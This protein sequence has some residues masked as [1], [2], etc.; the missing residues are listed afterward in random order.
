[1][2]YG[3]DSVNVDIVSV[4]GP[5]LEAAPSAY[6]VSGLVSELTRPGLATATTAAPSPAVLCSAMQSVGVGADRSAGSDRPAGADWFSIDIWDTCVE[7]PV[8]VQ[9]T[10]MA[11]PAWGMQHADSCWDCCYSGVSC[12]LCASDCERLVT[13]VAGASETSQQHAYHAAIFISQHQQS[14]P[15]YTAAHPCHGFRT[16]VCCKR[17]HGAVL[18]TLDLECVSAQPC[19]ARTTVLVTPRPMAREGC[20]M[21]SKPDDLS[22]TSHHNDSD[23][24]LL[25]VLHCSTY[26][27]RWSK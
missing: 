19:L 1:M 3:R 17:T 26:L 18:S 2:Q 13:A 7:T 4:K 11:C 14:C 6:Q 15:P 16:T 23:I 20:I 24:L 25:A 10:G 21:P 9:L 22:C 8:A 5:F 12:T 27:T